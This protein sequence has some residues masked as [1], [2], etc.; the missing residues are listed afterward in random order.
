M[1]AGVFYEVRVMPAWL[2]ED[3]S[4][5]LWLCF[6]GALV[7]LVTFANRHTRGSLLCAAS[8]VLT[9]IV[10]LAVDF[11]VLTDR[12]AIQQALEDV[13]RAFLKKDVERV[14]SYLADEF[15]FQQFGRAETAKALHVLA[16]SG[17][18]TRL[19]LVRCKVVVSPTARTA[20]AT[21]DTIADGRFLQRE[22]NLWRTS[23]RVQFRKSDGNRWLVVRA[24]SGSAVPLGRVFR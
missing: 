17:E 21:F 14:L 3:P 18:L 8:F 13:R 2:V 1:T 24:E 19:R 16:N 22:Y 15:R 9:A 10:L 23:W 4:V 12:E 11:L 6:F 5:P 7:S 20:E